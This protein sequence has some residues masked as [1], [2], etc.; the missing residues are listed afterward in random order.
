MGNCKNCRNWSIANHICNA[1][2]WLDEV[3]YD[4]NMPLATFG[5]FGEAHDDS[6]L[7][8]V[9]KTGPDF[10]CIQFKKLNSK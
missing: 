10:G 9:L 4:S 1:A 5:V 6:G 2:D 7:H 8:V 3:K